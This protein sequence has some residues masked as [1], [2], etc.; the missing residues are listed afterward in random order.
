MLILS[1]CKIKKVLNKMKKIVMRIPPSC[2]TIIFRK[3]NV[4][5][6][7]HG[8]QNDIESRNPNCEPN[9]AGVSLRPEDAFAGGAA[10]ELC[11]PYSA[12]STA[13]YFR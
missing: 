6:A 13:T 1:D 12:R 4:F 2:G 7:E 9:N 8:S 5:R 3:E 10:A 11:E